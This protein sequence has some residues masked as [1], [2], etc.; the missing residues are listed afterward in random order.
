MDELAVGVERAAAFIVAQS[1]GEVHAAQPERSREAQI[2]AP[3]SCRTL[4]GFQQR[5][6]HVL[7]AKVLP[8]PAGRVLA[9]PLVVEFRENLRPRRTEEDLAGN[10]R[11]ADERR[12]LLSCLQALRKA[13]MR[14]ERAR[15]RA[16]PLLEPRLEIRRVELASAAREALQKILRGL[17]QIEPPRD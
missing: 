6:H 7:Q 17:A 12:V 15:R 11:R 3:G 16:H 13:R 9:R 1:G 5:L 8:E 2:D 10:V 4:I 14:I